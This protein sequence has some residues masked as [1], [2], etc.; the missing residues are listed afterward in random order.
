M[1]ADRKVAPDL[2]AG[3]LR[4]PHVAPELLSIFG[5][6]C[7]VRTHAEPNPKAEAD[8][9][10]SFCKCLNAVTLKTVLREAR[11]VNFKA[12]SI[13][14]KQGGPSDTF[15]VI[16]EGAA[17]LVFAGKN[18]I[19]PAVI[20]KLKKGDFYG[21]IGL[22]TNAKR[23]CTVRV[24][25][26]ADLLLFTK[27]AFDRLLRQVPEF[28][29]FLSNHMAR[30]L[31][32][33]TTQL[34]VISQINDLAGDLSNFDLTTIFQA[35]S[36]SGQT[37]VLNVQE[38]GQN[39]IGEFFFDK[40]LL[41]AGRWR[42][43]KGPEALWQLFQEEVRG[44]FFFLSGDILENEAGSEIN[45]STTELL[46]NALQKRDELPEWRDKLPHREKP[47]T[48]KTATINWHEP[49]LAGC[50]Q[51]VWQALIR[52]PMSTSQLL[53]AIPFSEIHV[54]KTLVQLFESGQ[55]VH[56]ELKFYELVQSGAAA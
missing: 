39:T 13:I 33:T 12:G 17:E 20:G 34:A 37:G 36:N 56:T 1:Q 21:E 31:Q 14:C 30:R 9:F 5:T 45:G 41:R 4:K 47:I 40:G 26:S 35:I 50:A 28:L 2:P 8:N 52:Q 23:N 16:N 46:M 55:V 7:P 27:S 44:S 42:H 6:I 24:P 48:R 19:E 51:A 49:E 3:T 18:G 22:L 54:F 43:M 53:K 25:I 38:E 15:F 29:F 32:E 11:M 10:F